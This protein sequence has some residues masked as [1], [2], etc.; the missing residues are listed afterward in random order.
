[1]SSISRLNLDVNNGHVSG[2]YDPQFERVAEEFVRN[3]QE[4]GE[5]GAS[6]CIKLEGE[7]VLDLW[8]GLARPDTQTPWGEDTISVIWS[9]TK[10]ATALCAHM[11]ASRGLLDLEAP[12]TT[13][14]PEF[15]QAGKENIPVKMLLNHQSGLAALSEPLPPGAFNDWELMIKALE[16]QAPFWKPGSMHGYHGFTFGWLVGE[17]VRRISGKSLGSFFREEV[18]EP[19]GLDFWIGLPQELEDRVAVMIPAPPP[20]P[21]GPVSAMFAAMVDPSSLQTLLMFNSGG[22]MLPGSDGTFGFNL[23]AAHAAE[24][25]AAGGI[26]NARGLAG[27]YAPL[28]NG[29]SLNGVEL[30]SKDTLA[31]MAAVSSASSL[32]ASILAPTRFALGYVKTIDN[33]RVPGCTEN[34]S[35]I[36]SEEAFGHSGFGGAM[37]FAEPAARMSF[38]YV[39]NRMG[40]GLGL[41]SRG[42]SLIDAA[43][44]SLGYTSNASGSWIK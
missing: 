33:R 44:L 41:N 22:H 17:V 11:L 13:Y 16:R 35:V 29:G 9:A 38:G 18:A 6:A 15:G 23:Q 43:Y 19:L 7:T 10:G 34:D 1:M 20:D 30:V 2:F 28:A 4:R 21:S 14:W 24:I 36:L 27:L 32:D 42:Q 3:F 37:G 40:E 5:V 12:V 8:G 39:M 31:R 25:G 26:S